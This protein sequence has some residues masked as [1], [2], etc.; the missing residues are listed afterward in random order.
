MPSLVDSGSF[1]CKGLQFVGTAYLLQH[2]LASAVIQRVLQDPVVFTGR[3][4]AMLFDVR[5]SVRRRRSLPLDRDGSLVAG[6]LDKLWAWWH[7]VRRGCA[8]VFF[9]LCH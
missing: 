6:V 1:A 3:G 4:A 9:V 8:G 2:D 7:R 5:S